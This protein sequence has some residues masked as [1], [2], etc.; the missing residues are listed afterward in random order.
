VLLETFDL[1]ARLERMPEGAGEYSMIR[2]YL[3]W[4]IELPCAQSPRPRG[5]PCRSARQAEDR[6]GRARGRRGRS[7]AVR[8]TVR[9]RARLSLSATNGR[10]DAPGPFER[11][12]LASAQVTVPAGE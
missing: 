7:G 12:E 11:C 10:V 3:D 4:L 5:H 8:G 1:K 6:V 9:G 2:T